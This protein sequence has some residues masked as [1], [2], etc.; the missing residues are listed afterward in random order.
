MSQYLYQVASYH[1]T[2]KLYTDLP[3]TNKE[4]VKSLQGKD[5][6]PWFN[7][8]RWE[9][10]RALGVSDFEYF[11]HPVSILFAVS[12]DNPD[13]VNEEIRSLWDDKNLPAP[14][15]SGQLDPN[16]PKH[17]LVVHDCQSDTE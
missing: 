2:D 15:K 6:T 16:I 13:N 10:L 4:Y 9:Y 8:Y 1:A 5:S 11:E 14:F 12:S 17:Y 3:V 7:F